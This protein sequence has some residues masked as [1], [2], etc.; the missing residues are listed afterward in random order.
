MAKKEGNCVTAA[1]ICQESERCTLSYEDFKKMCSKE[2][3]ECKSLGGRQLCVTLRESLRETVLWD[4]Q[5]QDPSEAECVKVRKSLLEDICI[6]DAQLNQAPTLQDDH[7]D[8][9]SQG[10]ASGWY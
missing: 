9:F 8:T 5:C 6:Q 3:E 10:T 1:R 7:E 2:A 4:C